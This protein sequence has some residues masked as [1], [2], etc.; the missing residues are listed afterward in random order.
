MAQAMRGKAAVGVK[1]VAFQRTPSAEK[2]PG[3]VGTP[4]AEAPVI[5]A[6]GKTIGQVGRARDGHTATHWVTMVAGRWLCVVCYWHSVC[7]K[8]MSTKILVNVYGLVM[9]QRWTQNASHHNHNPHPK[10]DPNENSNPNTD[11]YIG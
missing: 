9:A 10:T 8:N 7:C 3:S 2:D 6:G 1:P 5:S 4:T 11:V